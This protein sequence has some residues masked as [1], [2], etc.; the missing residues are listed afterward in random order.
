M[1]SVGSCRGPPTCREPLG[2]SYVLLPCSVTWY[3]VRSEDY[4]I[5]QTE[6]FEV[7]Y[8]SV[9]NEVC[10][11]YYSVS[12][13]H[14][15]SL[16]AAPLHL[17]MRRCPRTAHHAHSTGDAPAAV[18]RRCHTPSS[19]PGGPLMCFGCPRLPDAPVR[20]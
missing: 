20:L 9:T 18:P 16:V 10:R 6:N 13:L 19:S 11:C 8:A 14:P 5:K 12:P 3:G 2:L 15:G 17:T 4:I 7:F 1:G